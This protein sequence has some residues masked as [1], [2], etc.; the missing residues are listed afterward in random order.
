MSN[1]LKFVLLSLCMTNALTNSLEREQP[2]HP[3]ID[4]EIYI[5]HYCDMKINKCGLNAVCVQNHCQCE[6]GN[7]PLNNIDCAPYACSDDKQCLELY[8]NS[9]CSDKIC[10]CKT[11]LKECTQRCRKGEIEDHL[12][13][14]E[15]CNPESSDPSPSSANLKT[16]DLILFSSLIFFLFLFF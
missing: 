2:E 6:M 14:D 10:R 3:G 8:P 11:P 4:Y 9:F 13:E 7:Q 5:G 12:I 15:D 16:F 1:I